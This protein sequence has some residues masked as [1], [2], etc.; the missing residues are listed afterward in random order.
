MKMCIPPEQDNGVLT[1]AWCQVFQP[2]VS[3]LWL[4]LAYINGPKETLEPGYER[5]SVRKAFSPTLSSLF[6]NLVQ[7]VHV[8]TNE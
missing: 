8:G 2:Q 6:A 7:N 5:I 4:Q 1:M 3:A